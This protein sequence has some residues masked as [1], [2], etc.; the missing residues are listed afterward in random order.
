MPTIPYLKKGDKIAIL[1]T[2]RKVVADEIAAAIQLSE[3]W[4]LQVEV[5]NTIDNA[6]H[7]FAGTDLQRTADLQKFLNDDTIKAIWCARG[8]YGTVKIIDHLNFDKFIQS[9]KWICGFSDVT[10]LHTHLQQNFNLPS[11]HSFMAFNAANTSADTMQSGILFKDALFGNALHYNF[12]ANP[13]N[14]LGY[15]QGEIVGGNLSML[16]SI[17]GSVSDIDTA[18]KIL[19]IEDLDEYLYHIDRMMM[20]LKRNGKLKNLKALIVGGMSD[21]KDNA[22]PFGKTAEEIIVDAV[23]DYNFPVCFNFPAGHQQN[24]YPIKLGLHCTIKIE[25]KGCSFIQSS[26]L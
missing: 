20:Q 23:Q 3:L 13:L 8:G 6:Y 16:Y 5:G 2:A 17:S 10:V 9:P 12:N 11:I 25:E 21:M 19:F 24:N 18:D 26:M 1:S 4:G 14:K 7:Q 15:A 22:T